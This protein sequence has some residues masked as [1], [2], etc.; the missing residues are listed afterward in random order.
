M[1]ERDRRGRTFAV[2]GS[3]RGK[4]LKNRVA[5]FSRKKIK[6]LFFWAFLA[7]GRNGLCM[8]CSGQS[9]AVEGF[10]RRNR[11]C[12]GCSG[13]RFAVEGSRRGKPLKNRVADFSRKKKGL[14]FWAFL[15]VGRNGL[16]MAGSRRGKPLKSRVANFSKKRDS[17]FG[18]F[19][20][21]E[22][23]GYV[24]DVVAGPRRGKP[25]K[26]VELPIFRKKGTLLLGFSGCGE[27]QVMYGM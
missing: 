5:D 6:G 27:K 25:V 13:R 18:L 17:T 4:P 8:G 22:E 2:E 21:W 10:R 9:F 23:T 26:K 14:Y 15:A 24:W 3:R 7:V 20:L 11:L 16:C 19:W 1:E 12:M